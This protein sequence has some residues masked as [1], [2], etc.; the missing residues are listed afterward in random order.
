MTRRVE[1]AREIRGDKERHYTGKGNGTGYFFKNRTD[2]STFQGLLIRLQPG[3]ILPNRNDRQLLLWASRADYS[4]LSI[5]FCLPTQY[6]IIA[7]LIA[8][9]IMKWQ[10]WYSAYKHHRVTKM[11]MP[12]SSESFRKYLFTVLRKRNWWKLVATANESHVTTVP[13][14]FPGWLPATWELGTPGSSFRNSGWTKANIQAQSR[15]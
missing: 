3:P 7:P 11:I 12:T 13:V 2:V 1:S 6:L 5:E 10:E 9:P 4:E 8:D 14:A 15:L